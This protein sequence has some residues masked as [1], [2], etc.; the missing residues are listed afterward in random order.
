[1]CPLCM[2]TAVIAA[3]GT[4]SGAG[5]LGVIALKVRAL[6]RRGRITTTENQRSS[7]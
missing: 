1:M 5:V 3:A 2:T 7:T 6:R 4:A